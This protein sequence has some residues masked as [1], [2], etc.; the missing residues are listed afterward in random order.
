MFINPRTITNNFLLKKAN[1]ASSIHTTYSCAK[2]KKT[3]STLN[4]I[5]YSK[6]PRWVRVDMMTALLKHQYLDVDKSYTPRLQV[7]L[8]FASFKVNTFWVTLFL[9]EGAHTT[10]YHST[11]PVSLSLKSGEL[12]KWNCFKL[13]RIVSPLFTKH[14][15]F[16]AWIQRK[17][18][19]LDN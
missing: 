17:T 10:I 8:L 2:K 9:I 16:V 5:V 14:V 1:K 7:N 12:E 6:S 18:T 13:L 15:V 19:A 11:P 3:I 4:V